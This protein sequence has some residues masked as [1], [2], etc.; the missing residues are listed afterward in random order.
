MEIGDKV[1]YIGGQDTQGLIKVR[2][3]KKKFYTVNIVQPEYYKDLGLCMAIGLK[4][5]PD[6][7]HR[8]DLFVVIPVM[9]EQSQRKHANF[10]TDTIRNQYRN[11]LEDLIKRQ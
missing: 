2:L 11:S 10:T 3:S 7:M 8:Q 4:E 6:F 9:K 5:V 1:R